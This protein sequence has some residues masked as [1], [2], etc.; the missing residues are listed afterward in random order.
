[1]KENNVEEGLTNKLTAGLVAGSLA[2]AGHGIA[3][4]KTNAPNKLADMRAKHELIIKKNKN[5]IV[6]PVA[7]VMKESH[8]P[9]DVLKLTIPLF[10]RLMEYAREDAK[11][12]M[13]LHKV[14]E[15][16]VAMQDNV[17]GMESYD[18]LVK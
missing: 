10:I 18:K 1:L 9:E 12:D 15:R 5:K 2:L 7:K 13:D 14:A 6:P 8:N 3:T 4:A 17:M 16:A 11:T